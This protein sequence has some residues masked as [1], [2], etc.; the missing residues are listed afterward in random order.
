MS[1]PK[2]NPVL[3]AAIMKVVDNQ[4]RSNDPPQTGQ[5]LK[6]LMAAGHSEEEAKRLIACVVSAE[7]FD[8]LK[9]QQPFDLDRFIK[10]L[11]NL[12]ALPWDE[13]Q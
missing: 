6:R 4:L 3:N 10:G 5:T 2:A 1:E 7:I 11:N 9:Q 12:P 8:V 13:E